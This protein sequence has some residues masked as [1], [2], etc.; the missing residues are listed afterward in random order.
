VSALGVALVFLLGA[1]LWGTAV[2][3]VAALLL[4]LLPRGFFH[5]G[6]A[7]FDAPIAALWFATLYAYLRALDPAVGR[8]RGA[9][10]LAVVAGLALAT[11]HNAILLPAVV[12]PHYAFVGWRAA[13]ARG[14]PAGRAWWRGPLHH[15]P[16]VVPALLV[17]GPVVLALLWPWLWHDPFG[18]A[19]AW[20]A[21]HLHHVHYNFEN[22]GRNWNAPPFPWH[23]AFVTTALV[24]P[25]TT[26][27]AAALGAVVLGRRAWRGG[28]VAAERAPVLLLVLSA[29]VSLG[30][31]VLG[32]TPIFGAEKH[33]AA[34]MPT[35]ALA[36]GVGVV[37]AARAASGWLVGVARVP[38]RLRAHARPILLAVVGG[39]A[40]A[41]ALGETI[42]AQPYAL[43]SYNAI[44]GGPA[45]G[46]ELGMNR[47]FWGVAA[48]GVLPFLARYAPAAGGRAVPV[49][50]H[51]AQ[52]AWPLYARLG[53][54]PPGLPDAGREEGGIARSKIALVL[55]EKHF[56]RHDYL[57][58]SAYGTTRP[59]YVLTVAGVPLVSVYVR[60]GVEPTRQVR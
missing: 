55:H 15:R 27:A 60:P 11:K 46:A 59:A 31:F 17:G 1:E 4:V 41:G 40:V 20:I 18:H 53:L 38:A 6:M 23:V 35:L 10:G 37:A 39:A 58:W 56:A 26:L 3:L 2:G 51:D 19:R 30:V 44:A 22:L 13:R 50:S 43:S 42:V 25:A 7:T 48:R 29:A 36:A 32:D 57:I 54:L 28:A 24:V 12:L 34:A 14:V 9:L 49:Y 47:Q 5:A 21:F 33:W 16:L 8:L 52:P 45:G